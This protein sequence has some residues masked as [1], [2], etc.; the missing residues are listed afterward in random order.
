MQ[1]VIGLDLSHGDVR[2]A[3]PALFTEER[4]DWIRAQ[5]WTTGMREIDDSYPGG[6]GCF[7]YR[8]SPCEMERC[9][10]CDSGRCDRCVTQAETQDA[11]WPARWDTGVL[12]DGRVVAHLSP[13]ESQRCAGW[14]CTCDCRHFELADIGEADAA[15]PPAAR[16][17]AARPRDEQRV[18]P[19]PEPMQDALFPVGEPA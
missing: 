13:V 19:V 7:L 9:G 18:R 2:P 5:A 16:R 3:I 4:A 1:R 12:L 17:P 6:R 15:G 10:A 11:R 8:I 14:V